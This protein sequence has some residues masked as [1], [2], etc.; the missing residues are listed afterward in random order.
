MPSCSFPCLTCSAT[1]PNS[2]KSCY[3]GY[4][5]S[6]S[7]CNANLNCNQDSS[8]ESCPRTYYL[9]SSSKC[10]SCGI[11]NCEKCS[12]SGA[13]V[14]C[15][16][17]VDGFY[18]SAA[19][20]CVACPAECKTCSNGAFCAS[21]KDGYFSEK[22]NGDHTGRCLPCSADFKCLTCRGEESNCLTCLEGYE[23]IESMCESTT[24][25]NYNITFIPDPEEFNFLINVF[26]DGFNKIV[27]RG[28][29]KRNLV[30][31]NSITKGSSKVIGTSSY[32][33]QSQIG[34]DLD[35]ILTNLGAEMNIDGIEIESFSVL[36]SASSS[37]DKTGLPKK[38]KV[39]LIVGFVLLGVALI[40]LA[41]VAVVM[42][43]RN[44]NDQDG[45]VSS[46]A[47]D[48]RY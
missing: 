30:H 26:K 1:N 36:S 10:E 21:C 9:T 28:V 16:K 12:L 46:N 33:D 35:T 8:C 45:Y 23:L 19:L 31:I 6:G 24:K 38:T 39:G 20:A 43:K 37:S 32:D 42:A 27:G 18:L 34:S 3:G 15:T 40:V 13:S 11:T 47:E 44:K 17:C 25:L 7:S 22:F 4:S 5:L 2:C 48:Q 29:E 14:S 41:V